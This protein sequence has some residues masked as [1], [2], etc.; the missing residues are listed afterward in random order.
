VFDVLVVGGGAIGA[1]VARDAALRGLSVALVEQD[2]FASGTTSRS[3]RLI[4]GGL[5][6]LE[7]LDFGLVRENLRERELLLRLAPHLV[8]PLPLF[9]PLY[10]PSAYRRAKLRAGMVLYD[11]LSFRK[12]LPGREWLARDEVL[13]MEPSIEAEGLRGAWRF[14]DAH[15]PLIERLVI[16]NVVDARE[17]GGV[18]LNHARAERWL[19]DG[20]TVVGAEVVDTLSG[21]RFSVRARQTVNATGAWVDLLTADLRSSALPLLR[22]TKGIHLVTPAATRHAYLLFARSDGRPFFVIPWLGASLIG[23]TDTDYFDD[24]SAAR[25][26]VEDVGYLIGAAKRAFPSAPFDDV[27]YTM[28]GVRALIRVT[29]VA[30]GAVPREHAVLDHARTDGVLGIVSVIGGKLTA[31]RAIAEEVT[32]LVTQRLGGRGRCLTA[33]TPLPGAGEVPALTE[34]LWTVARANGLGREQLERLVRVYGSR[35]E[36]LI[37]RIE[38]TPRLGGRLAPG[39]AAT[40]VEA[41]H[42]ATEEGAATLADFLLRR[43]GLGLVRD[44]GT[45]L[46]DA[47]ADALGEVL[48]WDAARTAAEITSY[49]ALI[50]AGSSRTV[51]A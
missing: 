20:S 16:E 42:A 21:G 5:R 34:R 14:Y 6:Y 47:A 30:E 23:T 31:Y 15:A 8:H 13:A 51:E 36:R 43:S 4:H 26:D 1:G 38:A 18:M 48:G 39:S 7:H 29:D 19:R 33:T 32:D 17:H 3:T 40:R 44:R 49:R 9:V 45:D 46:L 50:A 27:R 28:A 37:S 12:R 41:H 10:R 35:A 22:L 11:L 25:A 24:P 2:D